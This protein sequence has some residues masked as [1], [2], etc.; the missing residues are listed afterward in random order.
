[1]RIEDCSHELKREEDRGENACSILFKTRR[2][3]KSMYLLFTEA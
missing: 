1:M 2:Q 3:G